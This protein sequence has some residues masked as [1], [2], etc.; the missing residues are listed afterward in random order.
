MQIKMQGDGII[1][2]NKRHNN[3]VNYNNPNRNWNLCFNEALIMKIKI[4]DIIFWI[5]I[6]AI[7]ALAIWLLA[8]S[9]TDTS[10]IVAL[11]AF[12]AASEILLWKALFKIDKKTTV[13]FMRLKN[14][15]DKKH[16]E[17]KSLIKK[18]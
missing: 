14:D 10:A 5:I 13:G 12:V 1:N 2:G 17:L 6:L 15:L 3:L 7:I 16:D 8:G 4:E 18:K 11:V 9:P